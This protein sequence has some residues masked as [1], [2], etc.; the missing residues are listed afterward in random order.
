MQM[1]HQLTGQKPL[2]KRWVTKEQYIRFFVMC[3]RVLQPDIDMT[4]EEQREALEVCVS[5]SRVQ[6]VSICCRSGMV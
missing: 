5:V 2:G 1:F 6:P 3:T 4:L